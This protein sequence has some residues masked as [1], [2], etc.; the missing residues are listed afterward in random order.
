MLI[1]IMMDDGKYQKEIEKRIKELIGSKNISYEIIYHG[2]LIIDKKFVLYE[3]FDSEFH[4][5][6]TKEQCYD[7]QIFRNFNE[8][9][10]LFDKLE[11]IDIVNLE[12]KYEALTKEINFF[13]KSI[14]EKEIERNNLKKEIQILK[15]SKNFDLEN[16][17]KREYIYKF[18]NILNLE[19]IDKIFK[20][21]FNDKNY[22]Q[23]TNFTL[24]IDKKIN[25]ILKY[26]DQNSLE[27]IIYK[28]IDKKDI[29]QT[30]YLINYYIDNY[31]KDNDFIKDI[32]SSKYNN[33]S[34]L[35]YD[36]T[37]SNID[38]SIFKELLSEKDLKQFEK[39]FKY[40]DLDKYNEYL[41]EIENDNNEISFN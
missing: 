6:L 34:T 14:E 8:L 40:K 32:I 3:K 7:H 39:Y 33:Y 2:P 29:M 22:E 15:I 20:K 19:Y 21:E 28:M 30:H 41:N 23:I 10:K 24:D 11:N 37:K 12:K 27:E 25:F 1:Q 18:I 4:N 5:S 16:D 31:S 35:L 36:L 26:C 38:L 17:S 13:Q 9:E